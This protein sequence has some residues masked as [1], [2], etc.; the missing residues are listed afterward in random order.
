MPEISPP[1]ALTFV[2]RV[3]TGLLSSQEG[4]ESVCVSLTQPQSFLNRAKRR[5]PRLHLKQRVELLAREGN[6]QTRRIVAFEAWR[7]ETERTIVAVYLRKH[8][9][10][11]R[12]FV[13]RTSIE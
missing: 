11:E 2:L 4:A 10:L 5:R 7:A 6:V 8:H 9:A 3:R 1:R 12:K 13:K